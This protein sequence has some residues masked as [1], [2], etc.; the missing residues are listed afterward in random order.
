MPLKLVVVTPV[1]ND[2]ESLRFLL[3][4][5]DSV[6]ADV[7]VEASVIAVNDGSPVDHDYGE[8]PLPP[9]P[10]L[11]GVE[12][13][14]LTCNLGHQRAIATGLAAASA[15]GE[16]DIVVVM[17]S[18]GEDKPSDI[19]RLIAAHREH[20]GSVVV[21]R[22]AK[23]SEGSVFRL[24]YLA[25]KLIFWSMTSQRVSF[26]NFCL[27]PRVRLRR[28]VYLGDLWNHLAAT[29]LRSRQPLHAIPTAR[30]KRYA[31][32]SKMRLTSL[33][34]LGMSAVAVYSDVALVRTLLTS[35]SL[36]AATMM[37]IVAVTAVRFGT[38]MAIPGWASDVAGSL[39]VIAAQSLVVS[40]VVLFVILSSRAQR[41]FI[42]AKHHTDY[43]LEWETLAAQ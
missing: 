26:G 39:A 32:Q 20:P 30:G 9:L 8:K 2:W 6:L 35:V 37:G 31:G 15:R 23:R 14:H 12:V 21:A 10:H 3:R 25:Y 13:L 7:D 22:R 18:D 4:D 33:V 36:G 40:V 43:I 29:M 5:I 11:R 34:V 1:F 28:L 19:P 24:G 16:A 42:P 41:S 17:D 27:I 38:E